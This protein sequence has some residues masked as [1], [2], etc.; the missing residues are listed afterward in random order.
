MQHHHAHLA[1]CALENEIDGEV[2]GLCWDGTGYGPDGT[3]WGGESLLGDA[4]GFTRVAS[5][6]PS[7]CPA[8]TPRVRDGGWRSRCW[9][10]C[11]VRN[12]PVE[13]PLFRAVPEDIEVV[14]QMLRAGGECT[15]LQQHGPSFRWYGGDARTSPTRTPT[16]PSRRSCLEYAAWRHGTDAAPFDM[17]LTDGHLDWAPMIREIVRSGDD[18]DLLAAR[19]HQTLIEAAIR[20]IVDH[21]RPSVLAGGVFCNRYLTEGILTRARQAGMSVYAHSQ[22]PPTDGSLAAGQLWVGAQ[23]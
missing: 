21:D 23:R 3:V 17:P 6:R 13:L 1:A 15:L 16:R 2:L 22:L 8:A 18:P 12:C 5:L 9:T 4:G 19:F 11:T 14:V 7:G 20:V 10:R